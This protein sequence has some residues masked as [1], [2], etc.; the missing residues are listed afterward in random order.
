MRSLTLLVSDDDKVDRLCKVS[1]DHV[2]Q[3]KAESRTHGS[4]CGRAAYSR[5]PGSAKQCGHFNT[6]RDINDRMEKRYRWKNRENTLSMDAGKIEHR[7]RTAVLFFEN[8][9][10]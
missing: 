4:A 3:R 10:Y 9:H 5:S 8:T 1:H 6:S 7:V 2:V